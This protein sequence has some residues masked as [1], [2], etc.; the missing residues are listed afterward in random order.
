VV[1][2]QQNRLNLR[3]AER[4][5]AAEMGISADDNTLPH[6]TRLLFMRQLALKVLQY[7]D[8]FTPATLATARRVSET[9]YD[10]LADAS[11]SAAD[12]AA[13]Y[14]APIAEAG[15]GTAAA[16]SSLRWLLPVGLVIAA[17]ILLLGLKKKVAA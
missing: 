7:P 16:I 9:A 6:D 4:L 8:R 17:G 11:F 2:E 12:F 5:V 13:A 14:V 15:A 3:S 1:T 10:P